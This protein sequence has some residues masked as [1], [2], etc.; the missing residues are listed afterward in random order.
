MTMF[1][2]FILIMKWFGIYNSINFMLCCIISLNNGFNIVDVEKNY[3]S[4]YIK[5]LSFDQSIVLPIIYFYFVNMT[6]LIKIISIYL[7]L[8]P[9]YV[10]II[11]AIITIPCVSEQIIKHEYLQKLYFGTIKKI[12]NTSLRLASCQLSKTINF[13]YIN[14]LDQE[15]TNNKISQNDIYK[16]IKKIDYSTSI[17]IIK[18]IAYCYGMIYVS[19]FSLLSYFEFMENKY[20][21]SKNKLKEIYESKN[22]EKIFK[23]KTIYSIFQ[24]YSNSKKNHI[25]VKIIDKIKMFNNSITVF[26]T[27]WSLGM[28]MN[29]FN[30]NAC[31]SVV[32]ISIIFKSLFFKID[33]ETFIPYLF[34][35]YI[36]SLPLLIILT[37]LF[38]FNYLCIDVNFNFGICIINIIFGVFI[39]FILFPLNNIIFLLVWLTICYIFKK[40]NNIILY[41][42][43]NVICIKSNLS[44]THI[45]L[46]NIFIYYIIQLLAPS[47]K[48]LKVDLIN[49]YFKK[50]NIIKELGKNVVKDI[51]KQDIENI[52]EVIVENLT[53]KEEKESIKNK[54]QEIPDETSKINIL[55]DY[56]STKKI[57]KI[58]K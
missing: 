13:I 48:E 10:E 52:K 5:Y 8:D 31:H 6:L 33:I 27:I 9:I 44:L 16:Y 35:D 22:I 43:T 17:I 50:E 14:I 47:K 54:I 39:N 11:I 20:L 1:D 34:Y 7:W 30:F 41:T 28:L 58:F 37:W 24:I 21:Y 46:N 53:K 12:K 18:D 23:A 15:D 55:N 29:D 25:K 36:N 19:S 42:L 56:F 26:N 4:G 57:L 45:I 3:S 2:I 51:V 32:I 49:N 40:N 38:K